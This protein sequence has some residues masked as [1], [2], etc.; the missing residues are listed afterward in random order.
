MYAGN[1]MLLNADM[2]FGKKV[3]IGKSAVAPLEILA[4]PL[5]FGIGSRVDGSAGSLTFSEWTNSTGRAYFGRNT[6]YGIIGDG[7]GDIIQFEGTYFKPAYNGVLNLGTSSNKWL[8]VY[9]TTYHGDNTQTTVAYS[10]KTTTYSITSTD[11]TIDC[12]SGTFTVTLPTA[13]GITGRQ[14]V[15]KNSGTGVITVATTSS[16]TI[17]GVTTQAISIQ[18]DYLKVQSDGSNWVVIN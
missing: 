18:Y 13:V 16:Q 2:Y 14:Y 11:Y 10:A 12:T 8:D 17:D 3:G 5:N 4:D 1:Q 9:A 6:S 15:I 7:S